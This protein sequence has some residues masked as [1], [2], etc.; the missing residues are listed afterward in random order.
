[1]AGYI[2]TAVHQ[3]EKEKLLKDLDSEY[4]SKIK[5]VVNDESRDKLKELLLS[6]KKEIDNIV[7]GKVL[8]EA[9]YHTYSLKY[10]SCFEAGI[11]AE[12][13]YTIFKNLDLAVLKEK[14]EKM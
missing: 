5:T 2:I 8:L 9:E 13:I 10:G 14:T 3:E 6:A 11:G 7:E 12:A 4:K 1:F